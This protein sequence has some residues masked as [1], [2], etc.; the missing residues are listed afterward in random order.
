[1]ENAGVGGGGVEEAI[2]LCPA[3]PL[4][5]SLLHGGK[6]PEGWRAAHT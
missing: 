4:A 3:P 1:M 2:L 5:L 6:G